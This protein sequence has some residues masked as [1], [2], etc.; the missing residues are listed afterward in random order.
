MT[1]FCF[2][3]L[4]R[5]KLSVLK[6]VCHRWGNMKSLFLPSYCLFCQ[7]CKFETMGFLLLVNHV[8]A[9][10][11]ETAVD[12]YLIHPAVHFWDRF[13]WSEGSWVVVK[14]IVSMPNIKPTTERWYSFAQRHKSDWALVDIRYS[15][16]EVN[17]NFWC[18][19]FPLALWFDPQV[20]LMEISPLSSKS[21]ITVFSVPQALYKSIVW[22]FE[23]Q[24]SDQPI[25]C[26]PLSFR[27]MTWDPK[28]RQ[29]LAQSIQ[30]S[31]GSTHSSL[32]GS[33]VWPFRSLWWRRVIYLASAFICAL[34]C[35]S[36]NVQIN[37]VHRG[38]EE[39]GTCDLTA[40]VR[41]HNW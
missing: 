1:R 23:D 38:Q 25:C 31:N 30:M 16:T 8:A 9:L 7:T 4:F 27:G 12:M 29:I 28:P 41:W 13:S 33:V 17:G 34:L 19:V 15:K 20:Q 6:R 36:G 3:F 21:S 18:T 5:V 39:H 32:L 35:P 2:F 14:V 10:N 40:T 26:T 37:L 22:S 24:G 11:S